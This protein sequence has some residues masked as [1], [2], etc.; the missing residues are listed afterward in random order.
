MN[1]DQHSN[2]EQGRDGK[3]ACQNIAEDSAR[4]RQ[5]NQHEQLSK[6]LLQKWREL[7]LDR[8]IES[9]VAVVG[10]IFAAVLSYTAIYQLSAMRDQL[11]EMK[12]GSEDTKII[13]QS[14]KVQADAAIAA[15]T[16]WIVLNTAKYKGIDQG[17]IIFEIEFKNI[18]K[19]PALAVHTGWEA[20]FLEGQELTAIPK[21]EAYQ[22][23]DDGPTPGTITPDEIVAVKVGRSFTEVQLNK[24]AERKGRIVLHGCAQYH[25][26]LSKNER[27]TEIAVFYP[28]ALSISA[29]ES[30]GI[31]DPY[32]RMK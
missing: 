3:P 13:A 22:C 28:P 21:I 32:D 23:P 9:V 30:V 25:D 1:D 18:G 29:G 20:W 26:L 14:S 16:A 19:T 8:K 12:S 31:Y 6:P 4:E 27:I 11:T 24:V 2:K 7:G 17:R 15:T 5:R 10:L